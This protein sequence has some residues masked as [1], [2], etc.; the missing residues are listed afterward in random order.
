[1]VCGPVWTNQ[2]GKTRPIQRVFSFPYPYFSTDST[3]STWAHRKR[4]V[5]L[6]LQFRNPQVAAMRGFSKTCRNVSTFPTSCCWGLVLRAG[7]AHS[8]QLRAGECW[9]GTRFPP[10]LPSCI[11]GQFW[12]SSLR[13]V[14]G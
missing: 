11:H 12:P 10:S 9:P 7:Q 3:E 14:L 1:M 6:V 2:Q 8:H 13:V 5:I 4:G